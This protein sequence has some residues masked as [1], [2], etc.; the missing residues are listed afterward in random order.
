M[1]A[2]ASIDNHQLISGSMDKS[3]FIW[4]V[5]HQSVV[6]KLPQS[7]EILDLSFGN[8]LIIASTYDMTIECIDPKSGTTV[9]TLDGHRWEGFPANSSIANR[10]LV[11]QL[12]YHHGI[13]MSGSFDHT[14]KRWDMRVMSCF[15]TLIGHLGC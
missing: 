1:N 6:S 5:E 12:L 8:N 10:F 11:W 13:I 3:V 14:I 15:D 7:S 4:D 2:L 9:A